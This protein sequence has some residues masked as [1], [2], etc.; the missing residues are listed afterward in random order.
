MSFRQNH[1][2]GNKAVTLLATCFVVLGGAITCTAI[3]V[4]ADPA[5][6]E[7]T[8][9]PVGGVVLGI[10]MLLWILRERPPESQARVKWGWLAHR[11]R[12]VAYRVKP[13]VPRGQRTPAPTGPPTADSI[14]EITG[15]QSTWIPAA[16]TRPQG[17]QSDATTPRSP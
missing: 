9:I 17:P 14:R 10:A 8:L 2:S 11:T 13:R 16:T 15:R 1:D 6:L 3:A 7:A 5:H 12:K 4:A